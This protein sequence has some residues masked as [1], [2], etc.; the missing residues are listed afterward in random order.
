MPQERSGSG[1]ADG[2]WMEV[3]P[4]SSHVHLA[5]VGSDARR[6][7]AVWALLSG[8]INVKDCPHKMKVL[9]NENLDIIHLSFIQ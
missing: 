7:I 6:V 2:S 4:R 9:T 1:A 3:M 5:R 8:S